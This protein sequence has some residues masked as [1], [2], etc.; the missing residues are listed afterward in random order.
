MKIKTLKLF[1][2]LFLTFFFLCV[3]AYSNEINFSGSS[4]YPANSITGYVF[5]DVN[6]NS[7]MDEGEKGIKGILI[8]FRKP[9]LSLI[10]ADTGTAITDKDGRYVFSGLKKGLY[11]LSTDYD[12]NKLTTPNPMV[13]TLGLFENNS[14]V[15]FG[16][17]VIT[18]PADTGKLAELY[19]VADCN[20][21]VAELKEQAILEMEAKIDSHAAEISACGGCCYYEYFGGPVPAPPSPDNGAGSHSSSS[22][23]ASEYS[24]TNNQ[25]SGVDEADFIKNDGAY[26]YILADNKFQIIDAW[27][28]EESGIVSRVDI[29]GTP[30]KLFVASDRALIYSSLGHIS[31]P[32]PYPYYYDDFLY[33]DSEC[34]YGYDC[35]FSGDNRKLKIT[36]Y[37]IA[38]RSSPR[39]LREIRFSGSYINA[40]RIGTAIHSVILSPAFSSPDIRYQ[41]EIL[42]KCRYYEKEEPSLEEIMAAF[43]ALKEKNREII[44]DSTPAD[45]LPGIQDT[46]Y[47][48][49]EAITREG[50]LID[51]SNVYESGRHES[52]SFLTVLSLD[53]DKLE[54]LSQTTVFGNPGAVYASAS[55][56]YVSTRQQYTYDQPWYYDINAGIQQASTVHKFNLKNNPP[57]CEYTGSGV[58]KGSVLN[59]FAMDEFEGHL[60][61]ATTTGHVPDSNMYSTLSV[62]RENSGRLETVGQIDNIAPTED[63]RSVRFDGRN[64]FIV[65]FKKTDP[66]YAF[67]LSNPEAPRI[68]GELKIPGFPPICT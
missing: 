55:A 65:T 35:D 23:S 45:W 24:N 1:P 50:L 34:T 39:L 12:D 54:E 61:I 36:L 22:E 62:L 53:I 64:A 7:R 26:I 27:P 63:I 6:R 49:N 11:L 19:P 51:C 29:E 13:S 56:L 20:A 48:N 37:D 3:H 33:S 38:D 10:T 59:Q 67:D 18:Q 9:N 16:V 4:Y 32:D 17:G 66:L 58:V 14:E 44:A 28:P 41:P 52:K 5:N 31:T 42:D 46:R 57:A 15:N 68:E 25:V 2:A 60:R 47:V 43:E 30:K 8:S 40:R 21:L